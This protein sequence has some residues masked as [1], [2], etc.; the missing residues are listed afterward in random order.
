VLVIGDSIARNPL[1]GWDGWSEHLTGFAVQHIP[2][3]ARHTSHTLENLGDWL[4]PADIILWNN[5]IWDV[6]D[7]PNITP[8][9]AYEANLRQ[10][11]GRLKDSG[12]LVVWLTTTPV[13]DGVGDIHN[14][15]IDAYNEISKAVMA[16]LG[17][18]VIDLHAFSKSALWP[19]G[20]G[21][22]LHWTRE[23]AQRQ[24]EFLAME[25]ARI[26]Q[27]EPGQVR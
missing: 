9:D 27:A 25:L 22:G 11:G 12:A 7:S 16:E 23:A 4:Q 18:P 15:D 1:E 20:L 5:G 2:M 26:H 8:P 17:I 13:V 6:K 19:D 14:A 21:D 3:N 24:G 10:I